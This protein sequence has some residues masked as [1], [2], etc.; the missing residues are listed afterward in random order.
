MN[1]PQLF[2]RFDDSWIEIDFP[3]SFFEINE[4]NPNILEGF[5]FTLYKE[6]SHY[7]ISIDFLNSEHSSMH[8][9]SQ[10]LRINS[11]SLDEYRAKMWNRVRLIAGILI[12]A[13]FSVFSA[14]ANLK[15]ILEENSDKI[16]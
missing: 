8:R 15:K 11:L 10:I 13:L 14:V 3:D 6:A 7:Q 16:K 5:Q 2:A 4:S 12:V 9:E 1:P